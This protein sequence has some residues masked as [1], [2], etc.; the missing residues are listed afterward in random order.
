MDS[1]SISKDEGL[2]LLIDGLRDLDCGIE[3]APGTQVSVGYNPFAVA[4]SWQEYNDIARDLWRQW[5]FGKAAPWTKFERKFLETFSRKPWRKK[6]VIERDTSD[7]PAGVGSRAVPSPG[8]EQKKTDGRPLSIAKA[9][10]T[11]IIRIAHTSPDGLPD[12]RELTRRLQE[13]FP[14][15]GESTLRSLLADVYRSLKL[16]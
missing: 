12:R 1:Q 11:E 4:R 10:Y 2:D 14:D 3:Y 9:I 8:I 6:P 13:K 16:N 7:V 5:R 15:A